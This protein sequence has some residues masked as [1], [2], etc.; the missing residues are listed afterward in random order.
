MKQPGVLEGKIPCERGESRLESLGGAFYRP[1][2]N[3][4]TSL[5][6]HP[7]RQQQER[8]TTTCVRSPMP[9]SLQVH[10]RPGFLV[11][12]EVIDGGALHILK[13]PTNGPQALTVKVK[14][15]IRYSPPA[16]IELGIAVILPTVLRV[17]ASVNGTRWCGRWHK[18]RLREEGSSSGCLHICGIARRT[19]RQARGRATPARHDYTAAGGEVSHFVLNGC[20]QLTV[21]C[22]H[23]CAC[24][25]CGVYGFFLPCAGT[26]IRLVRL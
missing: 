5:R 23:A 22:I 7:S 24:C 14:A 11:D 26:G 25:S 17:P 10:P 13:G 15:S 20:G 3:V 1:T 21:L 8:Y 12:H 9:H 6:A 4:G 18:R 19:I 16:R 2:G